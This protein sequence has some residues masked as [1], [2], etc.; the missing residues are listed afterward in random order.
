MSITGSILVPATTAAGKTDLWAPSAIIWP[1]WSTPITIR[2]SWST[3]ITTASSAAETRAALT[4]KPM[5]SIAFAVAAYSTA[6]LALLRSWLARA[7][8]ARS[9]V[10]LYPDQSELTAAAL[11]GDTTI[12]CVTLTRRFYVGGRVAIVSPAIDAGEKCVTTAFE[13]G[14]I[15]ALD[16][17]SITLAAGLAADRPAGSLVLPLIEADLVPELSR[18]MITDDKATAS[19][20]FKETVG[21]MTLDPILTPGTVPEGVTVYYMNLTDERNLIVSSEHEELPAK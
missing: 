12:T 14:T 5:R 2:T 18:T 7:A 13:I 21:A 9:L 16:A 1:D 11:A 19:L 17:E 8:M 4:P 6:E 10:P 3:D 20:T 15:A